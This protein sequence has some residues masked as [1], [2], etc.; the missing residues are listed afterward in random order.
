MWRI[1][2]AEKKNTEIDIQM[3]AVEK[4]QADLR[5]PCFY[6]KIR[7]ICRTPAG[8]KIPAPGEKPVGL[9][10]LAACLLFK[11]GEISSC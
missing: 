10:K 9:E 4:N 8:V 5:N 6:Q 3:F 7:R 2:N 11:F 1:L